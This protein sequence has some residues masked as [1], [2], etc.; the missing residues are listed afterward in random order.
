M[1]I[2]RFNKLIVLLFAALVTSGVLF[3]QIST[4]VDDFRYPP[5]GKLIDVGGYRLHLQESGL[6]D[7]TVILDAGLALNSLDWALVQPEIAQFAHVY[8]YDRAG[9]GWSEKSPLPRTS[10]NMV[11]ELHALL[12]SAKIEPPYIL[13]GHSSGG[14]NIL[15][16][17]LLYPEEVSGLVFVD[18][19]HENQSELLPP[20]EPLEWMERM[21]SFSDPYLGRITSPLGISRYFLNYSQINHDLENYSLQAKK[22]YLSRI[23]SNAYA[24]TAYQEDMYFEESLNQLRKMKASLKDLPI[25]VIT[26]G[27]PIDLHDDSVADEDKIWTQLQ[28]EI[29]GLSCNSVHVFA[30]Q[31]D[32]MIPW[33][34]PEIITEA[35]KEVISLGKIKRDHQANSANQHQR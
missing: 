4:Y 27:A 13:V 17:A 8:S 2:K 14:V 25:V 22:A 19:V 24:S 29:V 9:L 5:S 21:T 33:H 1:I 26:A 32:H 12:H 7:H 11:E 18:S 23:K 28:Q 15:M 34:Q 6:G 30:R 31:S 3:Q 20:D 10:L 16:Y 35:V